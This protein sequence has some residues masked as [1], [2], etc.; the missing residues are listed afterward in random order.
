MVLFNFKPSIHQFNLICESLRVKIW[1]SYRDTEITY[2]MHGSLRDIVIIEPKP[3][4]TQ[5]DF[6]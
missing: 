2:G 3:H 5:R 6:S 4:Y 1:N